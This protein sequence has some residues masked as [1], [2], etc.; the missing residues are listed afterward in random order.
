MFMIRELSI[1]VVSKTTLGAVQQTSE[2]RE[3]RCT[4]PL[5]N[6]VCVETYAMK[7]VHMIDQVRR[8]QALGRA[9]RT[10]QHGR[11]LY[12]ASRAHG[13]VC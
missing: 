3:P 2:R 7:V 11:F 12:R 13:A 10:L 9:E 5:H 6:L 1:V 4:V 8:N